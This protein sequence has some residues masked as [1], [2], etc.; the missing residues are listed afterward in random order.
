MQAHEL[1]DQRFV[2]AVT[3]IISKQYLTVDVT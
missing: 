1:G 3:V 2:A